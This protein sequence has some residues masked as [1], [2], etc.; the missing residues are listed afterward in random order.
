MDP[1]IYYRR[2]TLD[3]IK[4]L[5]TLRLAFLAEISGAIA[6]D[7]ALRAAIARYFSESIPSGNFTA[8]LALADEQIIAASGM[9]WHHHPPSNKNPTG[10][11]AY[12]MNMFTQPEFRRRGIATRL[13][14]MLIQEARQ[15]Q[16]GKISLHVMPR[17]RSIY[18]QAGFQPIDTEMRLTLAK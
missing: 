9:T 2:A 10:G 7:D 3:D 17:G 14:E 1:I 18:S 4:A 6:S 12:I 15:N 11:E 13:L 8:F 16:C 5:T